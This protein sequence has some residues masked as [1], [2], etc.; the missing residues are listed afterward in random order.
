MDESTV[1][2]KLMGMYTCLEML[3]N[4]PDL[5]IWSGMQYQ[6][7]KNTGSKYAFELWQSDAIDDIIFSPKLDRLMYW[8][9]SSSKEKILVYSKYKYML[10]IIHAV[11]TINY[12]ISAV[13]HHGSM[14]PIKKTEAVARF[15]NDDRCRVFLS[16]DA[17][18]Y[19][20]DMNMSNLLI[21]YDLP[22]SAGKLDQRNSRHRR[23]SSTFQTVAVRNLVLRN[24]FEER[25]LRILDRKRNIGS[26]ILDGHG[27]NAQGKIILEGDSLR[28][29]L[30]TVV[31][32]GIMDSN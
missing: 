8:L 10:H 19:G 32:S 15:K 17:G 3:T 11:L 27:A 12:G 14:T 2:G 23:R 20:L 30:T 31:Q 21:N 29:H 7:G 9:A 18:A 25:R 1:S 28:E 16:S 26:A 24:S 22:W 4:H 13:Q 5:L 6:D